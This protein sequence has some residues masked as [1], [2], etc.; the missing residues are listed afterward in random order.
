M[1]GFGGAERRSDGCET[2]P[3]A[4]SCDGDPEARQTAWLFVRVCQRERGNLGSA[5]GKEGFA[6]PVKHAGVKT[7]PDGQCG[8]A[9][10]AGTA[11]V[12]M[13]CEGG[14]WKDRR[15][16]D[17]TVTERDDNTQR[18]AGRPRE[19]GVR[20]RTGFYSAL[21]KKSGERRPLARRSLLCH[22]GSKQ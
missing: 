6:R 17:A 20:S 15:A 12:E 19:G 13:T 18:N 8:G 4:K 1:G 22:A 3:D 5:R 7:A 21:Q 16:F 9:D 10:T 14:R 2:F 11:A